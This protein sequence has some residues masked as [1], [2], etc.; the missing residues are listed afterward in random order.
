M[1]DGTLVVRA[2][3]DACGVRLD[4][5]LADQVMG[6]SR[7][8]LKRL[9]DGGLVTIEGRV[10][11]GS[12]KLVGNE[13]IRIVK[14]DES[15][16]QS[17][18]GPLFEIPIVFEDE[19]MLIV[20]KPR[21]I[22]SHPASSLKEPSLVECLVAQGATL[23]G[24]E[25]HRPGIVH[26][27]DKP[28]TG[29]MVVAKRP[30]VHRILAAAIAARKVVRVYLV[31]VEG[32]IGTSPFRID[33]PIR[34]DPKNRLRMQVHHSGKPAATQ[35]FPLRG[36]GNGTLALA[37]LESGRTHQVRVHLAEI[38]HPVQG[39]HL[40]GSKSSSP[41]QLH[42]MFMRFRHPVLNEEV[43]AFVSPPSDFE[44]A[45]ND[46]ELREALKTVALGE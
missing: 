40:Y 5:Y 34:R 10:V 35:I 1:A 30:E 44:L 4:R 46:E 32:D 33:A 22:A 9:L 31:R 36:V 12:L 6:L 11:R 17:G 25:S 26:R 8:Q 43:S 29:L 2:A 14:H 18:E 7:S 28:T 21:G 42:S 13:E 37:K 45:P 15:P 23:A 41:L 39:D 38:R 27:L 16:K 3:E 24:G 19:Y 20:N